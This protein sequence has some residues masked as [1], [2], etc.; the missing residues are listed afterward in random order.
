MINDVSGLSTIPIW[1]IFKHFLISYQKPEEN[2]DYFIVNAG[3]I[4]GKI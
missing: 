3:K 4:A 1:T 2:L